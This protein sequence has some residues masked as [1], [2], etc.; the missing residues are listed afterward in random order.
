MKYYAVTDDPRELYHYGVKGMKWGQHIFGDKPKSPGYKRA[1]RKLSG[2]LKSQ[3]VK[4]QT[5]ARAREERKYERAIQKA[6]MRTKLSQAKFKY[7]QVSNDNAYD[8]KLFKLNQKAIARAEKSARKI[9][10]SNIKQSIAESKYNANHALS[11][12]KA[13]EKAAKAEK[14]FDKYL[15]EAREGRIRMAK[16]SNDQISR[17]QDRLNAEE[18]TRRLSGRE[19]PSWRQQKKEARRAGYLSGITKG[20]AAAMEEVARAGAVYGVQHLLDRKKLKS[21]AKLEGKE[22]KIKDTVRNKKSDK[23]L[24]KEARKDLKMEVYKHDIR[25][26]EKYDYAYTKQYAK[27]QE[28]EKQKKLE[29]DRKALN[30]SIYSKIMLGAKNTSPDD[31]IKNLN[32]KDEI[33]DLVYN[34]K[35]IESGTNKDSALKRKPHSMPIYRPEDIFGNATNMDLSTKIKDTALRTITPTASAIEKSIRRRAA[36]EKKRKEAKLRKGKYV[37]VNDDIWLD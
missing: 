28:K 17:I 3:K 19:K 11:N 4:L 16:L 29:N 25:D 13:E 2:I 21:K 8:D 32:R 35:K 33:Y 26:P 31:I 12:A 10:K 24:R 20:T 37:H 7:D 14:R 34:G 9:A 22:Q 27:I 36:K 30:D 1:A 6:Q 18:Q 5:N 23:E 15:Q